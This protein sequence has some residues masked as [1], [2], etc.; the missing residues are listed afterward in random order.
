MGQTSGIGP[1]I[2]GAAVATFAMLMMG[3]RPSEPDPKPPQAFLFV[4]DDGTG[5]VVSSAGGVKVVEANGF[6]PN[7]RRPDLDFSLTFFTDESRG[8]P[9]QMP[10]A[11]T[12]LLAPDGSEI[13]QMTDE[14]LLSPIGKCP[15]WGNEEVTIAGPR[16]S[17]CLLQYPGAKAAPIAIR[18]QEGF[19]GPELVKLLDRYQGWYEL[20]KK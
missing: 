17:G 14:W 10:V 11:G 3:M 19:S 4:A 1:S 12:R 8:V 7:L 9:F 16:R 2:A 6:R 5:L 15:L 13:G 20:S 18:P